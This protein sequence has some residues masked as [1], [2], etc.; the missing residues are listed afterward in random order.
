[1]IMMDYLE[2]SASCEIF[3]FVLYSNINE[4][5]KNMNSQDLSQ[6][7]LSYFSQAFYVFAYTWPR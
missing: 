4:K 3:V 6:G 7:L 2:I 1:M 5:R